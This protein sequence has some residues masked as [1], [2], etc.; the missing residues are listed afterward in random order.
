MNFY[1]TVSIIALILL[2]V[3]LSFV[4]VAMVQS[5]NRS[6]FPP[7][8]S[9]CPDFFV[10]GENGE[11]MDQKNIIPS[12]LKGEC[13][14]KQWVA[15]AEGWPGS[16]PFSEKC[17]KQKWANKCRVNWDGIT[18]NPDACYLNE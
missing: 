7:H 12:H 3:C 10:M 6:K 16:G 8:D 5:S 2:I 18:N 17:I 9:Q 15:P 1:K 4:G 11:C 13:D 14:N